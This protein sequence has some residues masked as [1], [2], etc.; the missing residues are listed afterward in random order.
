MA[1]MSYCRWENTSK[2]MQD[3]INALAEVDN[4]PEWFAGLDQYEREGV[5]RALRLAHFMVEELEQEIEQD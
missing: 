1:N 5:R 2:D 4:V 3:C